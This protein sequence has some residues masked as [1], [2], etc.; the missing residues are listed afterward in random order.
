MDIFLREEW[1]MKRM[2]DRRAARGAELMDRVRPG[3]FDEIEIE[4]LN[5]GSAK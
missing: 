4:D 3:G 2:V 5:I 1:V